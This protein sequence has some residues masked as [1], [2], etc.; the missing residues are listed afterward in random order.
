MFRA[1][2]L[3]RFVA[4]AVVASALVPSSSARALEL[5]PRRIEIAQALDIR[6]A[7]KLS[8]D[9]LRFNDAS[10]AP[11]YLLIVAPGGSAQA[12]MMVA[13]T[14]RSIDAPVVAVVMAPVS[15]AGAALALVADQVVMMPSAELQ[16]TEVDY[17][18]I[19][20]RDPPKPDAPPEEPAVAAQRQFQ[21]QLRSDYLK[22]F[23]TFVAKRLNENAATLQTTVETRGGFVVTAADALKKKVAVEVVAK[24]D[25]SRTA[26]EKTE[27]KATTTRNV[28][29]T[30]PAPADGLKVR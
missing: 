11:I 4:F 19:A 23:W 7:L 3:A 15:G 10:N 8:Q 24:I 27:I 13:D 26:D 22:R 6:G 17:E 21:Q 18:G 14:V 9:L 28:V 30:G 1:S 16:F 12:V 25:A 2:V 20:K 5:G 29:R